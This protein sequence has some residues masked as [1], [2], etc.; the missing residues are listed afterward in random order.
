M[1]KL[2]FIFLILITSNASAQTDIY[3]RGSARLIPIALPQLCL[4]G[5]DA[6]AQKEIPKIIQRDLDLSGYFQVLDPTSYIESPGKCGG[7]ENITYSDW[8]VIRADGVVRG[9]VSS[10]AG[11][12]RIQMYLHD[13]GK[14]GVVLG[15][16]YEGTTND[17]NKIAHRFANEIM[18]YYTGEYG[19]FGT[20]VAFSTRVGRFKELAVM[21]MDGSN[22]RQL[23][24]ERAL[25]MSSSWSPTG[26]HLVY[27]SYRS[28]VPDLF[29]IDIASRRV[30]QIT[31]TSQMELGA[32]FT[33]DGGSILTSITDGLQ[34]GIVYVGT[35]G[36]ILRKVTEGAGVIDVSPHWAPD[37]S[38]I[39]F[40]SN[41]AGGPQIYTMNSDGS[42]I[43]RVSFA[44]SNYCT[45][46]T[47]SPKGDKIAYVCR[48]DG[49][50]NI[51]VANYDGSDP[52]QL[53][54]IGSNEDPDW[55]PDGRYLVFASTLGRGSAFNLALIRADGSNIKQLTTS[56]GGDFQPSWGPRLE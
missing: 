48:S 56:R 31:R 15:K 27:T 49:G 35:D 41:R 55:S 2:F 28:R 17:V 34:S 32:K 6:F 38:R 25:A 46:P 36:R 42:N 40:C 4:Q 51:Y 30:S 12:I 45:S 8:S 7:P 18:K 43:K 11:G 37:Y 50:F 47:W 23:T 22:I 10:G 9:T 26:S 3:I 24:N 33:Q 5:G 44:S 39:I 29:T 52:M 1:K 53:T 14:Q 54:S 16:E 13:V 20:Q 19:P 21:D